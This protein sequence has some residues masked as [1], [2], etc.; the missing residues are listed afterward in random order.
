[1]QTYKFNEKMNVGYQG[2]FWSN[3]FVFLQICEKKKTVL[4]IIQLEYRVVIVCLWVIYE[5]QSRN[6]VIQ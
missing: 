1:M 4:A 5:I 6:V 3:S 2:R